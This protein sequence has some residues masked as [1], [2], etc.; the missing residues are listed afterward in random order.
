MNSQSHA[1]RSDVL[2]D[3][4]AESTD[5][6]EIDEFIYLISHD[7][8]ASVRA[9]LELPQWIQEDLEQA[10]FKLDG[11]VA[12]SIEML[13]RHMGRL[14]RMLMDLLTYSRAG[15]MQDINEQDLNVHLDQVLEDIQLLSGFEVTRDFAAERVTMGDRDLLVLLGG[16]IQNGM[17]H[18]DKPRGRIHVASSNES[19]GVAL[20]VSDDGPGIPSDFQGR[21]FGAMTTLRP[22]DEVEGSGMGLATVR[23]IAEIYGGTATVDQPLFGRGTTILV[24]IPLRDVPL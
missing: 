6:K 19:G 24:W 3:S 16:L 9:L 20:R 10:G 5:S 4:L 13:D 14:D 7:V 17:K 22:R 23:K 8:R 15:R 12:S 21:I 11:P 18:H 2:Q 1:K